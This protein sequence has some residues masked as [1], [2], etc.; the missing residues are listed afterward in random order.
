VVAAVEFYQEFVPE[1]DKATITMLEAEVK[2]TR[3]FKYDEDV[4][5]RVGGLIPD[6][7]CTKTRKSKFFQTLELY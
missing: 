7:G 6:L 5:H 2:L 4:D 1:E 3:E